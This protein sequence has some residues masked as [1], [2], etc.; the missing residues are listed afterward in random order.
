MSGWTDDVLAFWF[1][2]DPKRWWEGDDAL[3]EEVRARFY[4]LYQ[5]QKDRP[6][7]AFLAEPRTALAAVILLDQFPR[8]MFRDDPRTY[9]SDALAL[10]IAT[11]AV[12]RSW[13]DALAGP[14]QGF[15]LM[16]FQ[17]SED[18]AVQERSVELFA[19]IGDDD[20]LG[21]AR[22]HR[23]IV[24]RFGRFPHRNSILGRDPTEA[25]RAAGPVFPW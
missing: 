5:T 12:E 16:P 8:N 13:L 19:T 7:D 25:E 3:D 6:A 2:L 11:A 18:I 24:A 21:Y 1:A 10:E 4:D 23:D 22:K 15:L 20:Q 9:Q 17:H 14:E